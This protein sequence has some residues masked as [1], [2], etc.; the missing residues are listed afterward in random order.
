MMA[1]GWGRTAGSV[2]VWKRMSAG[3]VVL[4][5]ASWRSRVVRIAAE[6]CTAA[7]L[8][9]AFAAAPAMAVW[10]SPEAVGRGSLSNPLGIAVEESTGDLYVANVLFSGSDKFGLAHNLLSPPS[11]FGGGEV[12]SGL[13]LNAANGRV[14]VVNGGAQTIQSFDPASGEKLGEFSIAGSANYEKTFTIVQIASDGAGNV[15]LPNAPNNEVQVFGAEGGAPAGGVAASIKGEGEHALSGPTGVAVDS[16]GHVWVADDGDGR[17]EEF[18]PSGEFVKELPVPGVQSVAVDASGDVFASVVEAVGPHTGPHVVEF[19]S[20]GSRIEEF[21]LGTLGEP[22]FSFPVANAVAVDDAHQIVYVSDGEPDDVVWAFTKRPVVGTESP[23]AVS[24]TAATLRGSVNP[25]GEALSSC[26]FEY[27]PEAEYEVSH[28]YSHTIACAQ[29]PAQIGSGSEP[30]QVSAE[31]AGL[32]T[33]E[34]Y[35]FRLRASNAAGTSFGADV[36]FTAIEEVFGFQLSGPDALGM[37]VSNSADPSEPAAGNPADLDTQAGSHPFDV[38]TRFLINTRPDGA[39]PSNLQPK[40][41]YVD[42]PAGFAGSVAKV[43]RCKMSDLSSLSNRQRPPG[44]PTASQVGVMR[45]FGI[46]QE[47]TVETEVLPVYNMVPSS[48]VPAE[49]AFAYIL[50][51]EPV[52]FQLRPSGADGGYGIT[53]RVPNISEVKPIVGSQ[54]TLWGVPADPAHDAER[55][56][57]ERGAS[58]NSGFIPGDAEGKPLPAGTAEVP[59]LTNPTRCGAQE[60]ATINADSWLHPGQLGEDGRPLPGGEGWVTA[61]TPMFPNGITGCG[62]LTFHPEMEVKL[63]KTVA[64]SP[65]GLTVDLRVPQSEGA[66]NLA[67][68]SLRE[69]RVTLPQDLSISPS[70][71]NG[72]EGCT[73]AQIKLH[74]LAEPE[75]PNAS[76]VGRLEVVTPLLPEPLTGQIY[77]SSER[78]GS[79]FHIYLV[80]EGQGVLVKLEG[81]VTANEQTG[82]LTSTF[83]ENPQLPFS[84]LKL[85]F[86]GGPRAPLA[87]P[88]ACGSYQTASFF[89]PWSH[90]EANGEPTGTPNAEPAVE[91]FPISSGCVSGFAP[92][93]KAGMENPVAG[94]FSPFYLQISREDDEQE[95]SGVQIKMPKGLVGKLAGVAECSDAQIAHAEHNTGTAEKANPSC[96]TGSQI[97]IVQSAVGPGE[98]PFYVPGKAYLTGPYKG[99]PYGVV[100]IVPALAGPFDLGTIV[101]RSAISIDP[102]TAQVTV[103]SDPLPRMLAGIPLK[104]RQIEVAVNRHDFTLNPTSCNATQVTGSLESAQKA[105]HAV[106]ARFQVGDCGSLAFKPGFKVFTKARHT[107]RFGD[108]LRVK[109]TSGPGQA[110]IRS[111]LVKLPKALPSRVE[112]LKG[113]C[114]EKQF[115]ENPAGCPA[116]ARVGTA[117]A[118][119]PILS[120]P[121]TGP[122]IFVSH[123]GAAFPDLD[124]VLQGSGITVILEGNTNI[125]HNVTTSDFKSAPDVPVSSFELTLPTGAHSALAANGNLCF[126]TVKKGKHRI[127]RRVKLTM[128]TTITGQNGKVLKQR[129]IVAVEGCGDVRGRRKKS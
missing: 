113:A 11:P 8:M 128:P 67:T 89:E 124:I 93:F 129:T 121:L 46:P 52:T 77:L 23:A 37:V 71:A 22:T 72:L 82:Q 110:N 55:F 53:A 76:Q 95:L 29:S 39:L 9:V 96:P 116:A 68:P 91:P 16:G 109:V 40:D 90:H 100:V 19:D 43:P 111:V 30:V 101:V 126:K 6:A 69:A 104:V 5:G 97:G 127:K 103:T 50:I 54:L 75:C 4:M 48:G 13:T 1:L 41:Y 7:C 32:E 26:E 60:D 33:D 27:A 102:H 56:L 83:R 58:S 108:S 14:Y 49:L 28:S 80:V 88:N 51:G 70:Q 117:V 25:G 65:T 47:G 38:T 62:K 63:E 31:A 45:L 98:A 18:E 42:I 119:T 59:F 44:C 106:S 66:N 86:Y 92:G 3:E 115:A 78:Q 15:Y 105:Q 79:M 73:P 99:A 74:S 87:T 12:F 84:E 24:A 61:H 81:S 35:H 94:A 17:V 107:K 85:T 57:P 10:G 118:R 122:A 64:D 112:T 125:H 2:E 36:P 120:T 34:I 114:S 123:G 21:G 20:T